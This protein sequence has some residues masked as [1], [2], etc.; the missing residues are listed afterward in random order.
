[1]PDNKP[2]EKKP[3]CY[4]C[5]GSFMCCVPVAKAETDCPLLPTKPTEKPPVLTEELRETWCKKHSNRD[6]RGI[7][8][9]AESCVKCYCWAQRDADASWCAARISEARKTG[10]EKAMDDFRQAEPKVIT[11]AQQDTAREIIGEIETNG[12]I[13]FLDSHSFPNKKLWAMPYELLE[14]LKAKYLDKKVQG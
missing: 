8:D 1:M 10:Y 5:N 3:N 7:C 12:A 13:T 11:A 6:Q 4:N 14:A 2:T 9:T